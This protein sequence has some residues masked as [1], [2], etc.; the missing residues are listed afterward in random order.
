MFAALTFAMTLLPMMAPIDDLKIEDVKPGDGVAVKQFDVIEVQYVGT[1][2]DGKEFDSSTKHDKAFRFQVGI[3]QVIKGWDQGVIG[4]KAGGERN[5]TV[6]PELAYGDQA[7]GDVIPAKSTLKFNVKIVRIVPSA[8]VEVE[9]P[10]TG[11]PIKLGDILDCKISIKLPDG[12][13]LADPTKVTPVQ[14]SPRVI[15]GFNQA[16]AGIK[17][18]E[19]RKVTVGYELAFGEKGIPAVDQGD[20]KAGSVVP[21]KADLTFEIEAIKFH[22]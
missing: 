17:V 14:L 10:G 21:P 1:L 6:P 16:L 15:P 22:S 3:G 11:D 19:K 13:E 8:K 5:L 18:G 4:M 12:K 2:T 9:T 7:V 20:Q